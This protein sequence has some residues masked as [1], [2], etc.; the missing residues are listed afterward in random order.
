MWDDMG[1]GAYLP[2]L[3]RFISSNLPPSPCDTFLSFAP[4]RFELDAYDGVPAGTEQMVKVYRGEEGSWLGAQS[5][6]VWVDGTK[7]R[8]ASDPRFKLHLC[9]G[10]PAKEHHLLWVWRRTADDGGV[11]VE[12]WP[13]PATGKIHPICGGEVVTSLAVGYETPIAWSWAE[14]G[15]RNG[16]TDRLTL[17]QTTSPGAL[18]TR[19]SNAVLAAR[20][21]LSF[22]EMRLELDAYDGVPA[23]TEQMYKPYRGEERI[24]ETVVGVYSD[25]GC[26]DELGWDG[27]QQTRREFMGL[28]YMPAN[29]VPDAGECLVLTEACQAAYASRFAHWATEY[30]GSANVAIQISHWFGEEDSWLGAQ[31]AQVWVDGTKLRL[32]SDPR[33]KL[34]LCGGCPAKEHH[35]L[36]VWRRTADDGGVGVEWWPNPAT[37]KIHPICGGEI[38]TSLAV[39]Y[40][41]PRA[42]AE[43]G[44]RNGETDRLTLVQTASPGALITRNVL[45]TDD[46]P[47]PSVVPE[48]LPAGHTCNLPPSPPAPPH[49]PLP[50]RPI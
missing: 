10:C 50:P 17:V 26:T 20:A 19:R 39:G 14:R 28:T 33:F 30:G 47:W 45:A 48:R 6:Q 43:S 15:C 7:L 36:W 29:C 18:I 5:A 3:C 16:E 21:G 9:G 32:A 35:H 37:G 34:H 11:G 49:P 42:W 40:E 12:W 27:F 44:C 23:G 22:T 31:S 2:Y 13:N 24:G 4:I 1:C 38:D 46:A 8:L 25:A 41:T